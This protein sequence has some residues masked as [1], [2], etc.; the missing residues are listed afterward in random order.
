M[1]ITPLVSDLESTPLHGNGGARLVVRP[2]D[3]A[4]FTTLLP[5]RAGP[6]CLCQHVH[7]L[8]FTNLGFV[9]LFVM[10]FALNV[11]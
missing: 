5:E 4:F 9:M 10:F 7:I 6:A 2:V 3:E 8:I 11:G 1:T